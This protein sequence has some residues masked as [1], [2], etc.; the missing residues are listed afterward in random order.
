MCSKHFMI[1]LILL[2]LALPAAPAQAGGVVSACNETALKA[3]LTGGGTVTFSCS[4]T[5]TLTSGV[6]IA[7][8]TTIDGSGQNV[9]L[10]GGDAHQVFFVLSGVTLNLNKLT[11]ADGNAGEGG[12][13]RNDGTLTVSN[14]TFSGNSV[15]NEGGGIY[16]N[17]SGTLTVSN[18]TFADNQGNNSGG[19]IANYGTL[20][21]SN[22]TFAGNRADYGGG[23]YNGG[24]ATLKNTI[25]A[26]SPVGGN[27]AGTISDGGGNLSYPD[28]GTCPGIIHGDPRLGP[29]QAN[30]GPTQTMAL[31]AGS[32][33]RDTADAAIC[34]AAPVNNLDQRGVARPQG[35]GCDI[36]AFEAGTTLV[37]NANDSGPGS[38]RQ[39]LADADP[40]VIITFAG[41]THIQLGS[42]L[43]IAR[44]ATIDGA[45]RKVTISGGVAVRVFMVGP[46]VSLSLNHLTVAD[47][48]APHNV[49]GGIYNGGGTVTVNNSTV[50]GNSADYGGGIYNRGGTVTVSNS[51]FSGNSAD[52]H[53]GGIYNLDGT[54]TVSNST[55]AGNSA[56]N[57]GG[58]I[59]NYGGTAT[60][61]NTIVANSPAGGNCGGTIGDGGHNLS[62]PDGTCPGIH[63][64]PVLG[65]LQAN[66]G[67]TQTMALGAGSAARDTA[68]AATCAAAPVNNLDQRGVARPQGAGCDIGAFEART[69]LVTNANDGGPGSLRQALAD[70][71]TGGII[72]FAGDTHILLSSTL[73]I[74]RDVGIDGSWANRHHQRR[75]RGAR[76]PGQLRGVA[77]P[78]QADRRRWEGHRWL[79][80][81]RRHLQQRRHADGEQQHL[82][83]Q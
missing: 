24:T 52:H 81:R 40:G 44:D 5:I 71:D 14:S 3:A 9:T 54:V 43:I 61:K 70:A 79:R 26:N 47:G 49:G 82:R 58:G 41:D 29:L 45:G 53:G 62:Y 18:S 32:P 2:V 51:T 15:F 12:G 67:P 83:R 38:L 80:R 36:G 59:Y 34:A 1:V 20:T 42:T 76:V 7:A 78:E 28:D 30:G 57:T 74:A 46:G 73:N 37:T 17:T 33:A 19:G 69:T 13:I 22:S 27:C 48:E 77:Q 60:L 56:T 6:W 66:G 39:I 68:D 72:I 63:G 16:N 23:I 50:S 35:A 64:D 55:F 21:V 65:P 8:N 75:R 4:G 11:I 10:S 25:V 31:G